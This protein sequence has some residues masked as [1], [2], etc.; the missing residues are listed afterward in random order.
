MKE[1]TKEE[2]NIL[3]N[4][5]DKGIIFC[6]KLIN[7]SNLA[8]RRKLNKLGFK[9]KRIL[10]KYS[11]DEL[12][13]AIKKSNSFAE[14]LRNLNKVDSSGSRKILKNYINIYN[15]DIFKFYDK[16]KRYEIIAKKVKEKRKIPLSKILVENSTYLN[17]NNL[18][19]RLIQEKI[20][21]YK[22][23]NCGNVG[24][25]NDIKLSLQLDHING[26]RNDNKRENLRLLCPNCHS[27][28]ETF[29]GK[30]TK[31]EIKNRLN[32]KI[33]NLL[34][35]DILQRKVKRPSYDVLIEE[36]KNNGY[37]ATGRK[38]GVSDHSIRKWIIWYK[39]HNEII[40]I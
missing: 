8:I 1:W 15:L 11:K 20:L 23:K 6:N 39:K 21:E 2:I 24:I 7:R 17:N 35:R 19:K 12:E 29:C 3:L 10:N 14:M 5:Y 18:K 9:S 13:N 31:E 4:N 26:I 33:K 38:Y 22:C 40:N 36:I 16:T 30:L 32:N 37:S 27:Q 34:N 28:T 25:W